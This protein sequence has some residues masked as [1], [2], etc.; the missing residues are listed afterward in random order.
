M[1]ESKHV[2]K[3]VTFHKNY[4][5]AESKSKVFATIKECIE[6]E[7]SPKD[8]IVELKYSIA[9]NSILQEEALVMIWNCVISAIEWN[10]ASK[11]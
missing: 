9:Q 4:I 6:A 10:T 1:Q 7:K 11:I 3:V 5:T 8:I 2:F